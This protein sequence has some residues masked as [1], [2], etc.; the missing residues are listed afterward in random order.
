MFDSF[1]AFFLD[2]DDSRS[3]GIRA[4]EP[5]PEEAQAQR[6]NFYA[7]VE[8]MG[9]SPVR[10]QALDDIQ[11]ILQQTYY[12]AGGSLSTILEQAIQNAH[13]SLAALNKRSPATDL[14]AGILCVAVVQNHLMMASAGPGLALLATAGRLDQFPP[15]PSYFANPIG[16]ANPPTI[17]IYRHQV[18]DGDVF[19]L[20]ESDW[21]LITNVKT[22]GG[23]IVNTTRLNRFDVVD[24]LR[25]QSNHTQIP[26][27]LMVFHQRPGPATPP[28]QTLPRGLPTSVSAP[29]PVHSL[30]PEDEYTQPAAQRPPVQAAAATSRPVAL[31]RTVVAP[32]N[33]Q[34]RISPKVIG[35]R[36]A[37]AAARTGGWLK[38]VAAKMLPEAGSQ[39]PTE[40]PP[41]WVGSVP[42]PEAAI[43]HRVPPFTPPSPT[44]G[45]RARLFI[46]LAVLIPLL[47]F[48]TVGIL[49]LREG[50]ATQA[51]G[52]KLVDQAEAQL[53]KA[54]QAL[55]LGDKAAARS[56]L[57]DAQR[58]L[59]EAVALIGISDR[60]RELSQRIRTELQKLMN[61]RSLYSL[62]FPLVEFSPD[63]S[64]H[65]VIVFDQ[66]VYVLDI[67]RQMVEH[68]RTD[69]GR[70]VVEER[71]GPV[72]QEGDVV[73]GVTVGRLVDIA[74]QPRIPGFADKAS[75][76]ILDRNNN[77]FRYNRVD[78][79]TV[80]RL[81][82]AAQLQSIAQL[83]T[84]NGRLYL[85]DEQRNQI[86]RYSPAGLGYD[87]PPDLWFDPQVQANLAGMV[88][89]AIDSDI[90]LLMENGTLLRYS[91]G[92]QLPFSLDTSA[93]LTGRLSDMALSGAPEGRIYLADGSQDR[94]LVFDKLG[95][96]IEQLQAAESNAL[97]GLRG[98]YLDEVSGTLFILTQ[99]SL[100]AHPLPN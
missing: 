36:L 92:R 85:A 56:A 22:L 35:Q 78:E 81:A 99:T 18:Q 32:K 86:L 27:M 45:S 75:L 2:D 41:T 59:N 69:P 47:A 61:V 7:L 46:L 44:R 72:L 20:G 62:D 19:F 77:V 37:E 33:S 3:R 5:E 95:N 34:E 10:S 80:V 28:V 55:T 6:G 60:S 98:L 53:A 93:G 91:Q 71:S 48:A 26:G 30:P 66:E 14:R 1:L 76:L 88:A 21:I 57:N 65:R 67:G 94:I 40:N 58:Y 74:W 79:A 17:A 100:Y 82:D 87:E 11:S 73:E 15:D 38:G 13:T 96:Y 51:E 50:A 29:P 89:L 16:G 54:E 70:A 43:P 63:T 42:E 64:P 49:N 84:Y 9:E 39:P 31:K 68:F 97:Q 12:T 90:W 24:Y 23:A 52:V 4:V 25:Q 8:L 83:E